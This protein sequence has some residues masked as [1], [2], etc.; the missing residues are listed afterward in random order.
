GP[1]PVAAVLAEVE[2]GRLPVPVLP[3]FV[4]VLVR[5]VV[6]GQALGR[7]LVRRRCCH[8]SRSPVRVWLDGQLS[9]ARGAGYV[10]SDGQRERSVRRRLRLLPVGT[11]SRPGLGSR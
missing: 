6:D 8:R 7:L 2:I 4:Q 1:V 5:D 9:A 11:G 10:T 3:A